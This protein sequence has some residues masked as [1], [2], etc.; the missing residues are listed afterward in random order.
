[1]GLKDVF[2]SVFGNAGR[3]LQLQAEIREGIANQAELINRRMGELIEQQARQAARNERLLK[4]LA[5]GMINQTNIIDQRLKQ[6][7]D[8]QTSTDGRT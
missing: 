8:Q 2:R 5:A 6:L 1:M 7:I 3:S 4:E